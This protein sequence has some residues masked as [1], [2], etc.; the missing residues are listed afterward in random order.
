MP[1][2]NKDQAKRIIVSPAQFC[3]TLTGIQLRPYQI[4]PFEAI[5]NS[6]STHAGR[7]FVIKFS[8]QSGKDELIANLLVFL[9]VRLQ[10]Q[11]RL[12][13]LRPADVQAANRECHGETGRQAFQAMVQTFV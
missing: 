10:Y 7:T 12:Y 9:M 3:E 1:P 2:S 13:R 6:I 4:E 11:D 8:R 5:W